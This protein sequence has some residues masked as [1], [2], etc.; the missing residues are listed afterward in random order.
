MNHDY[1]Q[2]IEN[3]CEMCRKS[4]A[5]SP[6]LYTKYDVKK[7]LRDTKGNGVVVGLTSV[8]QVDGTKIIDGVKV[9][10]EGEL[11]SRGYDI[12]ALTSGFQNERFGFE[13][14]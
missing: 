12:K 1:K 6:D 7:G 10:C 14:V 4:D 2:F 8:S 3:K 11:R 9:P 5:F 13:E